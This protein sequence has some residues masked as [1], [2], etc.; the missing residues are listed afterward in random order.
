MDQLDTIT[1]TIRQEMERMNTARNQAYEQS[2]QLISICARAIRAIHREEWEKAEALI[3]EAHTATT[4]LTD[5]ARPYPSLY[6]AGYTQDAVKEFV[7]AHLTYALVRNRPLPTPESLAADGA[8]W[9]NGLAEAATELRRRIL[10]IIRHGHS[11]E[12]ERL[13]D[14]MDQIYSILVT[15]DF[16][17]SI[18]GGLRRRTDTVRAVLERTRGDV[19]TSLRQ[20]DLENALKALE[21]KLAVSSEE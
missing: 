6:Y 17:D 11:D 3:A 13:L 21:T 5:C 1:D 7:E 20:S 12:A 16:N 10:D 14:E 18:T 15:F 2:R 4:A 8:T 19:T 9:L